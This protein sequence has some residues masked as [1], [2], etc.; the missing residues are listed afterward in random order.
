MQTKELQ[1]V[2][3]EQAKKL[4]ELGFDWIKNPCYKDGELTVE[5]IITR[6]YKGI[7]DICFAAPT[8]ALALKWVRDRKG[9]VCHVTTPAKYSRS[10]YGFFYRIDH[11]QTKS[12][13]N[14]NNYDEA[15][16]ALLDVL[17]N[18]DETSEPF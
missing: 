16:S 6:K 3:L 8:V 9:I 12:F 11:S 18:L 4:K 10:E 1:L 15:E 14:Y 5:P 13:R 17:L 2:T 7:E